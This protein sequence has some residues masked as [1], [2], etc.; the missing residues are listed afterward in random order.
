[1][2]NKHKRLYFVSLLLVSFFIGC[3][4]LIVNLRDNLIYFYSPT[5]ILMKEKGL[6][7]KSRIGGLVEDSSI[8]RKLVSK[9]NKEVEEINFRITDL[10]NTVEI[11]YIGILPDLFKEGQGVIVEGFFIKD[12]N[13]FN[14]K[15][16]L[17]KHDENYIPPEVKNLLKEH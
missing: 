16:V 15:K 4:V 17:A 11:K 5:E 10:E 6:N 12:E 1:M 14:A 13:I 9:G 3:S 8:K 7:K 2:K